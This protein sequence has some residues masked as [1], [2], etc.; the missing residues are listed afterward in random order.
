MQEH[1]TRQ[2]V[3][4]LILI[5]LLFL[6]D[7]HF[8]LWPFMRATLCSVVHSLFYDFKSLATAGTRITLVGMKRASSVNSAFF[9]FSLN[10][11]IVKPEGLLRV[12]FFFF[13]SSV[14]AEHR[15][16]IQCHLVTLSPQN[17]KIK[18]KKKK[19]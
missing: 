1:E 2:E 15:A 11:M 17:S 8:S 4:L 10:L 3:L 9:F 19:N 5:L 6:K 7:L 12:L 18:M 16:F 14:I 13:T